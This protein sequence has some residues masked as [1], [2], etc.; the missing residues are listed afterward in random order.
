MLTTA[1]PPLASHPTPPRSPRSVGPCNGALP[2]AE[3]WCPRRGHVPEPRARYLLLCPSGPIQLACASMAAAPSGH[4][5]GR[6]Q[7]ERAPGEAE[8]GASITIGR[9]MTNAAGT[10]HANSCTM[11]RHT[12][13]PPRRT[14]SP[15]LCPRGVGDQP[16]DHRGR[17]GRQPGSTSGGRG[18]FRTA[19]ICFVGLAPITN[20]SSLVINRLG[21]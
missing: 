20:L 21:A 8:P 4:E 15:P 16:P 7:P 2:I 11:H 13:R 1:N 3:S 12:R 19:D 14:A 6:N 10:S 9:S 5:R 17:R 18:Q